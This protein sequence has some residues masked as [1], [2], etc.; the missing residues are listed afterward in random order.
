MQNN[1]ILLL[2]CDKEKAEEWKHAFE[3]GQFEVCGVTGDGEEALRRIEKENPA[4]AFGDLFL[5]NADGIGVLATAQNSGMGASF[6][7]VLPE[8]NA[9][10][11]TE[12][13]N[14]G[15]KYC[16][17][18]P[19]V[20]DRMV[21]RVKEFLEGSFEGTKRQISVT[22]LEARISEIFTSIGIP[23]HIK[24]YVYLREGVRLTV[25]KPEIINNV[26]KE[27]YPKI[28]E[29]FSTTAS[30]VERAIRHAI[31]VGWNRGRVEAINAIFGARVYIGSEK[32]TNS[33]FIALVADKLIFEFF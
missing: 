32:P 10:L 8:R 17:V 25:E 28:G 24:G 19:Y 20:T 7:F 16:F 33:E 11:A 22:Q 3:R 29:R 5:K 26:T 2:T 27:L 12:I 13:M 21:K 18:S 30:K 23:P 14:R 4:A 15:A 6:F 1:K 9:G 31:E